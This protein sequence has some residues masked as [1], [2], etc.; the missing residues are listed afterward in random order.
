MK[1]FIL[2]T[3]LLFGGALFTGAFADDSEEV[4]LY[5][6]D[7]EDASSGNTKSPQIPL[8][9]TLANGVLTLPITPIDYQFKMYDEDGVLVYSTFIPAG[10]TQIVLPTMPGNY[11]IRLVADTYYYQGFISI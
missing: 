8:V 7:E 9:A 2:S 6:I 10:S 11:E 3:L 1:K 5:I 4:P